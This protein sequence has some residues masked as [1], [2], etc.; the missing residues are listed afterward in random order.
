MGFPGGSHS[1]ESACNAGDPGLIPG[2]GRSHG[3]GNGNPLPYSCLEN[4]MDRR[5]WWTTLYGAPKSQTQLSDFNFTCNSHMMLVGYIIYKES[6]FKS[7]I[8]YNLSFNNFLISWY[9]L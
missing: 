6:L 3:E 4:P 2:L 8:F 1:K 9:R 7:N 5:A